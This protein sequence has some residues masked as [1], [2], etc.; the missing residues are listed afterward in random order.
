MGFRLPGSNG[1]CSQY[2]STRDLGTGSC[3]TLF[4]AK[5]VIIVYLDRQGRGNKQIRICAAVVCFTSWQVLC[6]P[7]HA[8]R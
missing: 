7:C 2:L 1:P 6:Y 3:S 8:A 5:Y 4:F